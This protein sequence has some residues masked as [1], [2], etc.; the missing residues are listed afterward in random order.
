MAIGKNSD[1]EVAMRQPSSPAGRGAAE[2]VAEVHAR[3][4]A[5]FYLFYS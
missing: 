2:K 5:P 1:I 3:A 4:T